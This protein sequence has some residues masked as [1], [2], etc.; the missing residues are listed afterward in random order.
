M[1][2]RQ[3][4]KWFIGG[5][6]AVAAASGV[7]L[8]FS[9]KKNE[10]EI[11][12]EH[13]HLIPAKTINP[14]KPFWF[15]I[16][17]THRS[18]SSKYVK[19]GP[20][21]QIAISH[22]LH[23]LE[24][25]NMLGAVFDE[26]SSGQHETSK[27]SKEKFRKSYTNASDESLEKLLIERPHIDGVALFMFA[28]DFDDVYGFNTEKTVELIRDSFEN[29]DITKIKKWDKLCVASLNGATVRVTYKQ[30]VDCCR[31]Y[32]RAVV[33]WDNISH[34]SI[35]NASKIIKGAGNVAVIAGLGHIFDIQEFDKKGK[36]ANIHDNYN[37]VY[38]VP[39]V[40]WPIDDK[41]EKI[42]KQREQFLTHFDLLEN[43][44]SHMEQTYK[45]Y[46]EFSL[47]KR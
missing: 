25:N 46:I 35:F 38:V 6:V 40:D 7:S 22:I 5:A 20:K 8:L 26:G 18:D 28:T 42:N 19:E 17:Q 14:D 11:I 39:N 13:A 32:E 44:K 4:L 2:R 30:V 36:L 23:D 21:S 47:K 15:Y 9:G 31:A 34:E 12:A 41:R 27:E 24:Q 29:D 10:L 45:D 16:G 33:S 1:N 37:L 3:F 43:L